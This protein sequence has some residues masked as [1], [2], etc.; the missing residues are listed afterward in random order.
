MNGWVTIAS[1]KI[2]P[3][4]LFNTLRITVLSPV[5]TYLQ[6][7]SSFLTANGYFFSVSVNGV[8]MPQQDVKSLCTQISTKCPDFFTHLSLEYPIYILIGLNNVP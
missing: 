4:Q 5:Y 2:H 8:G 3:P 1:G 7:G 6:P